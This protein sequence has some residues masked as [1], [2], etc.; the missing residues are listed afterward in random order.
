MRIVPF[1]QEHL[2][3]LKVFLHKIKG[4]FLAT[5]KRERGRSLED[6]FTRGR[7]RML[8][9]I[10]GDAVAGYVSYDTMHHRSSRIIGIGVLPAL[11]GKSLGTQL[12]QRALMDLKAR[13]LK[14]VVTRT[15]ESNA[16]SLALFKASGFKRY[17]T[18]KDDRINGEASIWLRMNF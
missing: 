8:I 10:Q 12:L 9:A 11:R 16:A 14:S 3:D 18:V 17:K 13:G 5:R 1:Q 4:E 7:Y 15:W 2:L 6:Y